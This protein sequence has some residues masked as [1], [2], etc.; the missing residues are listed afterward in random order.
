MV[1]IQHDVMQTGI[2]FFRFPAH[3][4][5]VLRHLQTGRRHAAGVGRFA[6]GKQHASFKEQIGRGDGGW[7]VGAFRHGLHA[8]GN[9]LASG[10]GIQF[11]LGGARQSDIHRH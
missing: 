10:V 2:H 4:R 6:R 9:Q 1:D 11:V 7:H 8:V 5:G 3:A